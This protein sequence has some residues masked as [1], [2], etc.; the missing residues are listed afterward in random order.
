VG[1]SGGSGHKPPERGRIIKGKGPAPGLDCF[2]EAQEGNKR[3]TTG[4]HKKKKIRG[5]HDTF[6]CRKGGREA[7]GGRQTFPKGGGE[8]GA[9][10]DWR[11]K[12]GVSRGNVLR[13]GWEGKKKK[14]N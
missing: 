9:E 10:R 3:K 6:S 2:C 5:K 8:V 11:V 7:E 14:G 4:E 1:R 12:E 13:F